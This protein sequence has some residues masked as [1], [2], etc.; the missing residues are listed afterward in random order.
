MGQAK[1]IVDVETKSAIMLGLGEQENEI[2]QVLKDLRKVGVDRVSI[3]QYLRPTI[4]HLPVV[5]YVSPE[6]FE[7]IGDIARELGFGWVKSGPLVRSSYQA[8][9]IQNELAGK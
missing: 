9:E 6:N 5:S 7:R 4:K 8:E 1:T 2:I 3:G